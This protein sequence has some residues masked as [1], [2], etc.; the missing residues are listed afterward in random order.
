MTSDGA[1]PYLAPLAAPFPFQPSSL[2]PSSKAFDFASNDFTSALVSRSS[3]LA[4][5]PCHSCT[6]WLLENMRCQSCFT[7]NCECIWCLICDPDGG[8]E[9]F[10]SFLKTCVNP[11]QKFRATHSAGLGFL[12]H[13]ISKQQ[14]LSNVTAKYRVNLVRK[15]CKIPFLE[16]GPFTYIS[17]FLAASQGTL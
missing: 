2:A 10:R 17:K 14:S 9:C 16:N 15:F 8:T 12:R 4:H 11:K 7:S 3:Q 6:T 1:G 13:P 5:S